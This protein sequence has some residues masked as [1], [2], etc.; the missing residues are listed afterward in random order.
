LVKIDCGFGLQGGV[1]VR[2]GF[3]PDHIDSDDRIQV[4]VELHDGLL[5]RINGL[6]AQSWFSQ[7]IAPDNSNH[8]R[9]EWTT[10]A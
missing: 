10:I 4:Y 2:L 5:S 1:A 8:S 6:S 3:Y 7:C 9:S